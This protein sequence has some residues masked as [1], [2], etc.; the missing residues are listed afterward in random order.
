MTR[1]GSDPEDGRRWD[2]QQK[3]TRRGKKG[4]W[5]RKAADVGLRAAPTTGRG[6]KAWSGRHRG[7]TIRVESRRARSSGLAT[8]SWTLQVNNDHMPEGLQISMESGMSALTKVFTGEDVRTGDSGFDDEL[9]INGPV[10][11]VLAL[12]TPQVRGRLRKWA[13][14]GAVFRSRS[15][16]HSLETN[17]SEPVQVLDAVRGLTSLCASLRITDLDVPRRLRRNALSDPHA[18]VRLANLELLAWKFPEA[19]ETALPKLVNDADPHV[20]VEAAIRL[21]A[22]GL[23][24][25]AALCCRES[26]ADVLD[27]A[28]VALLEH[29][30]AEALQPLLNERGVL[31]VLGHASAA[32]AAGLIELLGEIGTHAAVPVLVTARDRLFGNRA[33]KAASAAA[34]EQ[35]LKREGATPDGRLSLLEGAGHGDLS[36]PD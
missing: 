30:D 4:D 5:D 19:L 3:R 32:T 1:F 26:D 12:L 8:Y 23:E 14:A 7:C 34:I 25:L 2:R 20:R 36:L 24:A 29:A 17:V 6:V 28:A 22:N 35:I 9:L 10:E 16:T 27:Q 11:T 21:G 18:G 13:K 15:V 31:A 33:V